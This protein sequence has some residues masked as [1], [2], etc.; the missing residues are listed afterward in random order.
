MVRKSPL[1]TTQKERSLEVEILE[2][3]SS[4]SIEKVFLVNSLKHNFLS[5]SQCAMKATNSC[6][7]MHVV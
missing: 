3:K 4:L 5:I 6:L 1:E 7:T 2:G